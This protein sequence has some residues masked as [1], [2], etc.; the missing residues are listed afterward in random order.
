VVE[1]L[2]AAVAETQAQLGLSAARHALI[3]S[4]ADRLRA[5]GHAPGRLASLG[6]PVTASR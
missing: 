6:D 5:T 2:D 3:T 1:L 4:I